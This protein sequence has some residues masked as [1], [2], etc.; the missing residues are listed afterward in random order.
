MQKSHDS[1][2]VWEDFAPILFTLRARFPA[3]QTRVEM[4]FDDILRAAWEAA[5]FGDDEDGPYEA[6]GFI[7]VTHMFQ[8]PSQED[9][10]YVA[11]YLEE[12]EK[13]KM[14]T[15]PRIT[16]GLLDCTAADRRFLGEHYVV[17]EPQLLRILMQ[18][19]YEVYRTK[20]VEGAERGD[21]HV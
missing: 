18:E 7:D 9:R 2:L 1:F 15:S 16:D 11:E 14:P 6:M 21:V 17:K 12:G 20:P 3:L 5:W 13:T 19:N 8:P 10:E 4:S